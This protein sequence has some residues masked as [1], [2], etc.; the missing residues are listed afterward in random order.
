[1]ITNNNISF[2]GILMVIIK[3]ISATIIKR[4][5]LMFPNK[6][7]LLASL[8]ALP[9]LV[10][11]C[12]GSS[13]DDTVSFNLA[14]SDAPVDGLDSVYI[15]FGD[16][17][18][19]GNTSGE[20]E[21]VFNASE[22]LIGTIVNEG[23]ADEEEII[24]C[25]DDGGN[26]IPNSV[27]LNLM[28]FTG[29]DSINLV[30]GK[31]IA[32]GEYTQIRLSMLPY[33]YAMKGEEKLP[34]SVPSNELKLDGFTATQGN[35]VSYTIEFD[36]RQGM[37]DPVGQ[38][39]YILKPRGVRLVDNNLS[40]HI[41]GTIAE[42][43]LTTENDCTDPAEAF[44]YLY[45]GHDLENSDLADMGGAE[46][47]AP[48]TSVAVIN[49]APGEYNYEI[50][51]VSIGNYSVALTCDADT[52]PEGNDN[53]NFFNKIETSVLENATTDASFNQDSI[54]IKE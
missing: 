45:P 11:G 38:E 19:K 51:F 3:K 50:G 35:T 8:I 15:C 48:I 21:T 29:S 25:V 1:M 14:V 10:T 22:S 7:S 42:S 34:V 44:V 5:L 6:K 39:G 27:S 49:P 47:I 31:E 12:G 36:F 40:G 26:E 33:S 32:V 18:L 41:T 24:A 2:F 13:S 30:A 54:I 20:G 17:E 52:D 9:I 46:P 43:L 4:E 53:V 37:T 16:I 23:A 28:Y